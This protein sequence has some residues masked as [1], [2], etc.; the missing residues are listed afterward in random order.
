MTNDADYLF[1]SLLVL[2]ISSL[3][4]YLSISFVHCLSGLFVILLLSSLNIL[5]VSTLSD[6]DL[7]IFSPSPWLAFNFLNIVF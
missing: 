1:V 7:H 6:I 5:N 2:C 4:K 3:L